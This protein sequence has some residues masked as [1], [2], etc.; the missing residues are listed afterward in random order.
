MLAIVVAQVG[1]VYAAARGS[2]FTWDDYPNFVHAL[3]EGLSLRYLTRATTTLEHFT[4]GHRFGDWLLQTVAPLNF[5]VAL[6]FLLACLAASTVLLWRVLDRLSGGAWWVL[7]PTATFGA[8]VVTLTAAQW[9]AAGL[10]S[11]PATAL[12]L[13]AILSWLRSSDDR[14]RF[15]LAVTVLA[16]TLAALF[17]VKALLV[18]LY[19]VLLRRPRRWQE[20]ALLA[21]PVALYLAAHVGF[22]Y[23]RARPLP[24]LSEVG[25]LLYLGW[26]RGLVPSL[27]N[28]RAMG[29]GTPW[30]HPTGVVLAQAGFWAL[31]AV[32]V[33]R[34]RRAWRGW[35]FLAVA[36]VANM[37]VHGWFRLSQVSADLLAYE[38]RYYVEL[39]YLVPIAVVLAFPRARP[40][41]SRP[42]VALA[43]AAVALHV[44]LFAGAAA[45][46]AASWSGYRA[47]P[48]MTNAVAD[49]RRLQA[50]GVQP[51]V[52]DALVAEAVAPAWMA[53][54]SCA[55]QAFRTFA[56]DLR[57]SGEG[58]RFALAADGRLEP[59]AIGQAGANCSSSVEPLSASV[60]D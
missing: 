24:P 60:E 32:S 52:L 21:L 6:G 36:F 18:P 28:V 23:A 12:S 38:H 46:S 37:A 10:H 26:L 54:Y 19:L 53:P 56:P 2:F 55:S 3:D 35:A 51:V 11:L 59:A 16:I 20:W 7:V 47:R 50:L 27:V 42:A 4:P 1:L 14:A 48:W 25:T 49:V 30:A 9:W 17:Y 8:S 45:E 43:V 33:W 41:P 57:F 22:G 34:D 58:P 29:E 44:V 15:A 39:A 40:A 5:T 13:L 31:V